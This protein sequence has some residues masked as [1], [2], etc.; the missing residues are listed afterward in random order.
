VVTLTGTD[1][2]DDLLDATRAPTVR[3]VLEGAAAVVAFHESIVRRVTA[4][5]PHIAARCAVVPQAVALGEAPYDLEAHWALPTDRVVFLFPAGIR[6]VKQPRLPLAAFRRLVE[7][8]PH[9][10]LGYVGPIIDDAEGVALHRELQGLSWARYLGVVP[11]GQMAALLR[12]S[13]VVLNCSL[14]E[15]GMANAVL[16]A[17]AVGRAVLAADIEGN[18][19]LVDDGV[20][21]LLFR[22]DAGLLS[23]AERLVD[24]PDLR[25]RLGH[26]GRSRVLT[27]YAPARE[28]DGYVALYHGL[29]STRVRT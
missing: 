1:A 13:D 3:R 15:G 29:V 23:A 11:H 17:L 20:T 12:A 18:R 5:L 19:S 2:N 24:D 16:E 27:A 22:D 9:V 28:I 8:R 10:R 6:P 14:S 7:R 25:R 26:A 4:A 21:G